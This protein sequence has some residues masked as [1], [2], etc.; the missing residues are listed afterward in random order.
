[1]EKKL[2]KLEG[3][4]KKIQLPDNKKITGGAKFKPRGPSGLNVPPPMP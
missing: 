2:R 4:K 3:L 1:M